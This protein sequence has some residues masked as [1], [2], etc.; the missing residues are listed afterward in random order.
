MRL[1]VDVN[2][3]VDWRWSL[4]G[5]GFNVAAHVGREHAPRWFRV[6]LNLLFIWAEFCVTSKNDPAPE[7]DY[8]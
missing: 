5:V 4:P 7:M 2:A 8:E 3:F 1:N 6:Q